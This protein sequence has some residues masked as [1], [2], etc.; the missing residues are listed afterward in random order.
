M[1]HVKFSISEAIRF[2]W[3]SFRGRPGFYLGVMVIAAILYVIPGAIGNAL[4]QDLPGITIVMKIIGYI[5]QLLLGIGFIHIGLKVVDKL[6]PEIADLYSHSERLV[7]YFI[8]SILYGLIVFGGLLLLVVP[9]IIWSVRFSFATF[10]V[11]DKKMKPVEALKAS[12]AATKGMF[13]DLFLFMIAIGLLNLLGSIP[14][15]LGLLIT[16]PI[17]MVAMAYVYRKVTGGH[18]PAAPAAAHA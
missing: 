12:Y 14:L 1:A 6:K 8:V 18:A 3:E 10:Y 4:R 15:G 11:I 16:V 5:I 7:D 9:G 13:W 17:T 2:G